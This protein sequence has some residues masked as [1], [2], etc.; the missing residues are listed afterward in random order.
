MMPEECGH[1]LAIQ[2][3]AVKADKSTNFYKLE[4]MKYNQLLHDIT[5]TYKKAENNQLRKIDDKAKT[6]TKKLCIDDCV[7]TTATKKLSS[8]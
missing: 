6:V 2:N 8:P 3:R 5:K 7:G 4:A 1:P